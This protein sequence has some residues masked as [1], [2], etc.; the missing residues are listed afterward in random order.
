VFAAAVSGALAFT[1]SA[2]VAAAS[3]QESATQCDGQGLAILGASTMHTIV[4]C[5]AT[6]GPSLPGPIKDR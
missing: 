1:P 3:S 5:T 4:A 2:S 6:L